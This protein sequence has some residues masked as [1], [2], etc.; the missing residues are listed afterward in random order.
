MTRYSI[1]CYYNT[2]GSDLVFQSCRIISISIQGPIRYWNE[3]SYNEVVAKCRHRGNSPG[4]LRKIWCN[5]HYLLNCSY[6]ASVAEKRPVRALGADEIRRRIWPDAE[7]AVPVHV[8][9]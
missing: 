8:V 3:H 1:N 7:R 4:S 2:N 6:G 9:L 5:G